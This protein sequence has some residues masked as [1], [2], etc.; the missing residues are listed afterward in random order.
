MAASTRIR[1]YGSKAS[2]W[3]EIVWVTSSDEKQL[4][5]LPQN[6]FGERNIPRGEYWVPGPNYV[7]SVDGHM[8]LELFGIEIYAGVDAYS[9]YIT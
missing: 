4:A 8:K 9:R 2:Q 7:W 3:L 1:C 5:G 6:N